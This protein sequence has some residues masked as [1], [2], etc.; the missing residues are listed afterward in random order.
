MPVMPTTVGSSGALPQWTYVPPG[1]VDD[2]GL[3]LFTQVDVVR[4]LVQDTDPAMPLIADLE[5]QWLV[6]E[7]LPKHDSLYMVAAQTAERIAAKFAGVVSV[8]AD[9][10]TVN[11]SDLYERYIALAEQLRQTHKDAQVGGEVDITNLM[12]D[13]NIDWSIAPL[14]FGVGMHDNLEAGRQ[15]YGTQRGRV[16]GAWFNE[17]TGP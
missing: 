6:D 9:G 11:V 1:T 7:W 15:D 16:G 14:S 12:W 4:M 2:D 5:V 13:Q 3:P 8:S 10:V 17:L